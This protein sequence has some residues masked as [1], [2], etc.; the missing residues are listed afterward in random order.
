[1]NRWMIS[2]L[3]L[4]AMGA[5]FWY[6]A[7]KHA[8][9]IEARIAESL[10]HTMGRGSRKNVSYVVDGRHVTLTGTVET[11]KAKA[12]AASFAARPRLVTS[13]DNQ[14]VVAATQ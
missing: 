6:C 9:E 11:A 2:L 7:P 4:V 1:M 5:L 10:S 8:G 13:V 14:I 3:G 12:K